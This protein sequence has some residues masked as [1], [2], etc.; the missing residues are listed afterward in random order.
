MRGL[1]L[2][3]RP[4]TPEDRVGIEDFYR[5]ESA[6]EPDPQQLSILGKLLGRIVAHAGAEL[7]G[8]TV[9]I[10]TIHVARELRRRRIGSTVLSELEKAAA[11]AGARS[12]VVSA[13]SAVSFF[14]S[15]G[16][17]EHDGMFRKIIRQP[18]E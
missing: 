1:R 10:S 15:L 5:Q 2:L 14:Q 3:V 8:D 12:L 18:R 6:E 17:I 9:L 13:G 11:D 7:A 16:F 4:A